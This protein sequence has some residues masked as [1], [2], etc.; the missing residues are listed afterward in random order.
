MECLDK[1]K[2]MV[3]KVKMI[4]KHLNIV[5]QT[6][7]R[8]RKLQEKITELNEWR[9]TEN[10][11]PSSLTSFKSYEIMVYSMAT[12]NVKTWPLSSRKILGRILEE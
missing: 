5:S 4:E 2:K 11:I 10:N 12:K 7:Q 1:I 6:H 9:N 8:M 3:D